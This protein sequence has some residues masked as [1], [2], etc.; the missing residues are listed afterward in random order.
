MRSNV[1]NSQYFRMGIAWHP[2]GYKLLWSPSIN[3]F[4][5][6]VQF[7]TAM[8]ATFR[9]ATCCW[10]G[11]RKIC[12]SCFV[13]VSNYT[14]SKIRS[15]AFSFFGRSI[16]FCKSVNLYIDTFNYWVNIFY[17]INLIYINRPPFLWGPIYNKLIILANC[18][19]LLL[20]PNV[21]PK[22]EWSFGMCCIAAL[23]Q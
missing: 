11:S 20:R 14:A 5:L 1:N 18:Q 10:S 13:S 8:P 9:V 17:L 12:V 21:H 16:F 2:E 23:P 22:N 4:F 15:Q 7:R 3:H 6:G 19:N